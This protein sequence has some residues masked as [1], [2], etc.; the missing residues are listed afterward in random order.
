MDVTAIAE[1]LLNVSPFVALNFWLYW[2]ERKERREIQK[3][4]LDTLEVQAEMNKAV[5]HALAQRRGRD[6]D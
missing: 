2:Q 6:D 5:R 3:R 1:S 4:L